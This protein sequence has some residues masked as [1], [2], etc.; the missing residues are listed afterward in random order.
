[1]S[2]VAPPPSSSSYPRPPTR[3]LGDTSPVTSATDE[4][5]ARVLD[6]VEPFVE[7][8]QSSWPSS[9]VIRLHVTVPT[10][11]T[12]NRD[13]N[14]VHTLQTN[15]F[16]FLHQV[17]QGLR[18]KGIWAT[19]HLTFSL[20]EVCIVRALPSTIPPSEEHE[21]QVLSAASKLDT[22]GA[23]STL[24]AL[25]LEVEDVPVLVIS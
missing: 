25:L 10:S 22:S 18:K 20:A 13:L 19:Y 2:I 23:S 7:S 5:F 17:V 24:N 21:R 9:A 6:V 11:P 3:A 1:M 14:D 16:G 15:L 12:G 8:V 4:S